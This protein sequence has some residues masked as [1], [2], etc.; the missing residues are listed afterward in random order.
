MEQVKLQLMAFLK[1][2][3]LYIASYKKN[4]FLQ[5]QKSNR[6][7]KLSHFSSALLFSRY[8]AANITIVLNIEQTPVRKEY[9]QYILSGG[10]N[11]MHKK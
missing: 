7:A 2:F 8:S 5:F 6:T 1:S 10:P 11:K 9:N 4:I 3:I